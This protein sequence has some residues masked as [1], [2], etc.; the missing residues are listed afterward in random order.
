MVDY[1]GYERLKIQKE[2]GIAIVTLNRP[3]V[4]NAVDQRMHFELST[5]FED[6]WNDTEVRAVVLTGAGRAFSSGGD[7]RNMMPEAMY[8][9]AYLRVEMRQARKIID[10]L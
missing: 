3:D 5:I 1:G 7:V 4:L 9:S 6:L 8:D 2:E 10:S